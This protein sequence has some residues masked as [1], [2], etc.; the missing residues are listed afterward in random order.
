[1]GGEILLRA[2]LWGKFE[3]ELAALDA[4]DDGVDGGGHGGGMG[5]GT[6]SR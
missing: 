4:A 1:M 6:V 3:E 5:M 2:R